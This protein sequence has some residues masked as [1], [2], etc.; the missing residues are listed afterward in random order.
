MLRQDLKYI[1]EGMALEEEK[2]IFDMIPK[3]LE[4]IKQYKASFW[5]D[6]YEKP[7]PIESHCCRAMRT[8]DTDLMS[9]PVS[10]RRDELYKTFAE[11]W[12]FLLKMVITVNW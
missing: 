11:K 6:W 5:N 2:E 1:E 10:A 7:L 8:A 12:L 3:S 4:D 9:L